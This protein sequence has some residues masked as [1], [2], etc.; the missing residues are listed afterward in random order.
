VE[1]HVRERLTRWRG[2]LTT[3]VQDGRQLLREVLNGPIRCP[4]RGGAARTDSK[5]RP[6][7]GGCLRGLR[8]QQVWRPQRDQIPMV[9]VE[10]IVRVA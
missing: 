6:N 7:S 2:L 4:S 1:R 5:G 9:T 10:G 8:C 3:Q